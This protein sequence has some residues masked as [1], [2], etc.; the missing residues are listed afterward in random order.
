MAVLCRFEPRRSDLLRRG[1]FL[2]LLLDEGQTIGALIDCRVAFMG[3][4]ADFIE[5]TV[6]LAA[7]VV[8]ALAHMALDGVVSLFVCKTHTKHPP[9]L[10]YGLSMH[11]S[12][13]FMLEKFLSAASAETASSSAKA[14]AAAAAGSGASAK[15]AGAR[16][17]SGTGPRTRAV[18]MMVREQRAQEQA[19]PEAA[20]PAASA[21]GAENSLD[22]PENDQN[23]KNCTDHTF[24][25][26]TSGVLRGRILHIRGTV[27]TGLAPVVQIFVHITCRV[28]RILS[29]IH[30]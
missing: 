12:D 19:R 26:A 13:R 18:V 23:R 22:N 11:A 27:Q 4:D 9:F 24:P 25:P 20:A 8:V 3:A 29:L 17:G 21:A 10:R 16:A 1:L 5:G 2:D 14:S 7:A 30:I 6:I 15:S 28:V